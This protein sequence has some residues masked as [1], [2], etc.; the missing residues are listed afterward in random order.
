M[1]YAWDKNFTCG[2]H[3]HRQTQPGKRLRLIPRGNDI[4]TEIFGVKE[5]ISK[6]ALTQLSKSQRH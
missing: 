6:M 2:H 3:I 4:L 5:M 1:H